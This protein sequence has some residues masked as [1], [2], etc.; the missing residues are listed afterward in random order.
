MTVSAMNKFLTAMGS[1]RKR[2]LCSLRLDGSLLLWCG[3]LLFLGQSSRADVAKCPA[4][5]HC[6]KPTLCRPSVPLVLDDCGCCSVCAR[7][8]NEECGLLRPCDRDRG[9][10]CQLEARENATTGICRASNMG[11]PC[12]LNGR[13]FQ[14]GESFMKSC[15]LRC[16]CREG[17]AHC[18]PLCPEKLPAPPAS[19][20][21]ARPVKVAGTCCERWKCVTPRSE[22]R[23]AWAPPEWRELVAGLG[24]A[25]KS[26]NAVPRKLETKHKT[27]N[28]DRL[29]VKRYFGRSELK[30]QLKRQNF[31]Y[32]D[33]L[34]RNTKWS[35]CSQ[36]CGMGISSRLS[37]NNTWCH[38]KWETRLCQIR[39]CDMLNEVNLQGGKRCRNSK[40]E[41]EPRLISYQGCTSLRKYKPKYCGLC[42]D[43]RCCY[44]AETRTMRVRFYCLVRGFIVKHVMK[45]KRCECNWQCQHQSAYFWLDN[46]KP[47]RSINRQMG[48][49]G[50]H[51]NF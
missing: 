36:T 26:P 16:S 4:Q 20:A 44:P 11:R 49:K 13:V 25:V 18:S 28:P 1:R 48:T 30:G 2:G 29:D 27:L 7:Q 5:C 40:K 50:I 47:Y 45:I 15:R 41:L 33:C 43:G 24:K 19:C 14:H 37:T 31:S 39:P 34:V 46:D 35:T 10:R 12:F 32:P 42:T 51:G 17:R 21:D 23:K 6:P 8:F 3:Y 22:D 9:L 38:P